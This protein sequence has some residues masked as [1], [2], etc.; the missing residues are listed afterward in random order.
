MLKLFLDEQEEIPWEALVFVTGHINYGGR[1]TDDNDRRCLLTT[2]Q[3]YYCL[4]NL[5]DGY[6][7][8]EKSDIYFAPAYGDLESYKTY[9]D[10]LPLQDGPEV[11]GL[12]ENANI[13]YQKQE[14]LNTLETVLSIQPRVA[15]VAGG[16]STDQIVLL[17]VKDLLE[18]TPGYLEREVGK[19][20]QFKMTNGLL[21]SLTTVLVQEMEKFNKMLRVMKTSLGD[22]EKAIFGFIVMSETLDRMYLA[23]QNGQV[24]AN[25]AKVAYPSLKPLASWFLD[26]QD[27]VVFMD[28]WLQHGTPKS[29]WMP[30]LFFPQG[31]MTGCLQTHARFYKIAIDKL[32]FVFQVLEQETLDEIE[33]AP[34]D[35]VYV[36]GLYMDGARFNR[37]DGVIDDQIPVSIDSRLKPLKFKI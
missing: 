12:H 21:P 37:E 4:E 9:I 2:L 6:Y 14:S 11:F 3:K 5:E 25:W 29:F 27:R 1:V 15:Q 20:E 34:E 7:Y 16:L 30:G 33:E 28:S 18:G 19:K 13:S 22:L 10:T 8:S 26:M 17:R 31:F 24:P 35:G 32:S 23:L 36:H